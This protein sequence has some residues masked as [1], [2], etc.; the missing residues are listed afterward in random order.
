[1][2]IITWTWNEQKRITNGEQRHFGV[3]GK[4]P[5]LE[6][7]GDFEEK[8]LKKK[9]KSYMQVWFWKKTKTKNRNFYMQGFQYI[10]FKKY[11]FSPIYKGDYL[12]TF[13]FKVCF[14]FTFANLI[15]RAKCFFGKKFFKK[16]QKSA[17]LDRGNPMNVLQK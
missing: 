15:S 7:R 4:R 10:I 17:I 6:I 3:T 5:P 16:S 8:S 1:M 13:D 11:L 2:L 12:A 14:F 9:W